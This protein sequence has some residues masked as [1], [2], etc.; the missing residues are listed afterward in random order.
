[1]QGIPRVTSATVIWN[2]LRCLMGRASI[3]LFMAS[4]M[5]LPFVETTKAED[6]SMQL[7][8]EAFIAGAT[9]IDPPPDEQQDTHAYLMLT[10]EA[11]NRIFDS[12]KSSP[13]EDVCR[14]DGWVVKRAGEVSCAL[15]RTSGEAE[16]D[17]SIDLRSGTIATG[18][19]C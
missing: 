5:A 14:G 17:F 3:A 8:G 18:P 7:R 12:L 10:G 2:R 6:S 9:I 1:V 19:P 15:N 16:C 11:A 13:T 4:A